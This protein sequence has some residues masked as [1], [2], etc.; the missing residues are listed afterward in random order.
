MKALDIGRTTSSREIF[1]A[2]RL[3]ALKRKFN[4]NQHYKSGGFSSNTKT[5]VHVD[6]QWRR[7][8]FWDRGTDER[9]RVAADSVSALSPIFFAD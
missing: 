8:M 1:W 7:K 2:A 6:P 9:G 5:A 4:G 3:R